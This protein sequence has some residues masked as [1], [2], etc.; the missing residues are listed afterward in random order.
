MQDA[1]QERAD[2]LWLAIHD[3]VFN[4]EDLKIKIKDEENTLHKLHISRLRTS[5][6]IIDIC[7]K[8]QHV[9]V[10]DLVALER[11]DVRSTL[12]AYLQEAIAQA[13]MRRQEL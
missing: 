12:P 1:Q 13:A 3:L 9:A 5:G 6:L 10:F 7:K 2:L 8:Y 4:R 11:P